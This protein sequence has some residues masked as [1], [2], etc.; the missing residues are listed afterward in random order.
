MNNMNFV[1]AKK[2]NIKKLGLTDYPFYNKWMKYYK[3]YFPET[4]SSTL[5]IK[6]TNK[7]LNVST[8]LKIKKD[9]YSVN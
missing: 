3:V 5:K 6:Y 9:L 8:T 2:A 4:N 7:E 1:K